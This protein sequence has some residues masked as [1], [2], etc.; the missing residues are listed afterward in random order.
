[1][2]KEKAIQ[3]CKKIIEQNNEIVKQT[4]KNKDINAMQLTANCDTESSAIE[5]LIQA[6]ENS[7][8]REVIEKKLKELKKEYKKV[9]ETNS[10][11]AFILKCQI[12]ILEELLQ[13]K[14]EKKC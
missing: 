12:E 11:Q 2:N 5:T 4:K 1:M 9:L 7:I 8:S 13:E 14:G 10:M 3:I 6:L